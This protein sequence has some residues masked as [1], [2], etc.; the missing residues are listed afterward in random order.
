[1]PAFF[2]RPHHAQT[3]SELRPT[4]PA[5]HNLSPSLFGERIYGVLGSFTSPH[6]ALAFNV[7]NADL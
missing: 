4:P 7:S 1:M 6:H 2:K 5:I 3:P